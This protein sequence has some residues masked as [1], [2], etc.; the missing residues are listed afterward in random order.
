[1]NPM[2]EAVELRCRAE[3][4][5]SLAISYDL[6]CRQINSAVA[7]AAYEQVLAAVMEAEHALLA[8]ADMLDDQLA[9]PFSLRDVRAVDVLSVERW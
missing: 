1:M 6:H 4:F 8:T 5:R 9:L 7:Q 2:T 3:T